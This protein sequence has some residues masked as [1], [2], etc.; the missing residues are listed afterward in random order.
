M[1]TQNQFQHRWTFADIAAGTYY[2]PYQ[3]GVGLTQGFGTTTAGAF[4]SMDGFHLT[5]SE[6]GKV[7][8]RMSASTADLFDNKEVRLKEIEVVFTGPESFETVREALVKRGISLAS[9][10]ITTMPKTTIVLEEKQAFQNMNLIDGLEDLDDVQ[11]VF[12]NLDISDELMAKFEE[13]G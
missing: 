4:V 11:E 7:S 10:E 13:Q 8:L 1:T 6:K 9:A 12:S 2:G 3:S 5:Q